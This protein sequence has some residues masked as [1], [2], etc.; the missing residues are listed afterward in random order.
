MFNVIDGFSLSSYQLKGR[1]QLKIKQ[2]A[3]LSLISS[4]H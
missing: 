1:V 3:Y 4:R 2:K